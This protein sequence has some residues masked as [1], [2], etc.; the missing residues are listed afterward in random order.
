MRNVLDVVASSFEFG[1]KGI[2]TIDL[3]D[4][5]KFVKFMSDGKGKLYNCFFALT[6]TK[7]VQIPQVQTNIWVVCNTLDQSSYGPM[8]FLGQFW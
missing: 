4:I 3:Q 8:G 7:V 2:N 5:S 6:Q 1:K